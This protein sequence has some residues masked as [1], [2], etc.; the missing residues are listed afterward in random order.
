VSVPPSHRRS[1]DRP[2]ARTPD[3]SPTPG[4]VAAQ[5]PGE[6]DIAVS[7]QALRELAGVLERLAR[8]G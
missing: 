7:A 5:L 4:A 8:R 6:A 3:R 2:D 1:A